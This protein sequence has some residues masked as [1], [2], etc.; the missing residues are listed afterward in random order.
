MRSRHWATNL[1]VEEVLTE[2][3]RT[4]LWMAGLGLLSQEENREDKGHLHTPLKAPPSI[5]L[6]TGG[7]QEA[8]AGQKAAPDAGTHRNEAEAYL[9]PP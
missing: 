2:P 1:G 5:T 4:M 9:T 3:K 8:H 7:G 6:C